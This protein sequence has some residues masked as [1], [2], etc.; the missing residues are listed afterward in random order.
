MGDTGSAGLGRIGEHSMPL[1]ELSVF[2][3]REAFGKLAMGSEANRSALCRDFALSSKTGYKWLERHRVSGT[4]G[5][6]DRSRRPHTSPS[7]TE[8]ATE[9]AVLR[10]RAGRHNARG[11]GK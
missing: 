2:D 6:V 1:R 5:L 9:A 3:Q 11:G 10:I 7:L 8:A 4:D